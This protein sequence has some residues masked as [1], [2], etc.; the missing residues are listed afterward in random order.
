MSGEPLDQNR[1]KSRSDSSEP[2]I[3]E[4]PAIGLT[5]IWAPARKRDRRRH[6]TTDIN[7]P[8]HEAGQG[9]D[10]SSE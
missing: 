5:K 4:V 9:S 6:H 8:S 10:T 1:S 3:D 7:A 2:T